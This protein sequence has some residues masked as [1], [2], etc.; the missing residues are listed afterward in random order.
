METAPKR[1]NGRLDS[2]LVTPTHMYCPLM[3]SILP[4]VESRAFPSV[5]KKKRFEFEKVT[6]AELEEL[7][8]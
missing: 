4:L 3:M 1:F 8:A 2:P 7:T 5:S 6:A